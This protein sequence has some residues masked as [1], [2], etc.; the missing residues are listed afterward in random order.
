MA[1][2]RKM[3]RIC[4]LQTPVRPDQ[5][6]TTGRKRATSLPRERSVQ[7]AKDAARLA[8]DLND[9]LQQPDYEAY[10]HSGLDTLAADVPD[11]DK[12]R[13][14]SAREQPE[15]IAAN[16]LRRYVNS[17]NCEA[18]CRTDLL[19]QHHLLHVAGGLQ[20]PFS[21][22]LLTAGF[23]EAMQE[24]SG[25]AQNEQQAINLTNID[26]NWAYLESG[27]EIRVGVP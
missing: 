3:A 4:D 22:L 25:D 24:H 19:G 26:G 6:A 17:L 5:G 18:R 7:V 13:F 8:R 9:L 14:I 16:F 15:E 23:V 10:Q 12:K 2:R 27:N 21:P 11:D 1:V 20:L